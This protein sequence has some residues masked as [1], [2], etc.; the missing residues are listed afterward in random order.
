MNFKGRRYYISG[1]LVKVPGDDVGIV[2]NEGPRY[3]HM[4]PA[5]DFMDPVQYNVLVNGSVKMYE[6][7]ALSLFESSQ[8]E[9]TQI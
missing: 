8:N 4:G 1:E 7:W 5:Q 2:V 3:Q 6:T 9:D